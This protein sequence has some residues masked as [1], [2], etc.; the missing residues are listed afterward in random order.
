VEFLFVLPL[1]VM[2]LLGIVSAGAAYQQKLSLTNGAREGAR[3]GATLPLDNY[4][5]L[6]DWLTSLATVS[7][8]AVD[9]GLGP[10]VEGRVVCVAYVYPIGTA[11]TDRTTRRLATSSEPTYSSETC[12]ADGRPSNERRVQ[13]VLERSSSLEGGVFHIPLTLTGK[14]VARYEGL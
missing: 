5:T 4:T 7:T 12:F 3:F 11:L 6:N 9:D 8:G 1:L 2:I 10:G 13:V 14:S